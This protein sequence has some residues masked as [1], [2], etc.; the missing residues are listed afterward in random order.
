MAETPRRLA[1]FLLSVVQPAR[2]R[3][4]VLLGTVGGVRTDHSPDRHSVPSPLPSSALTAAS[5]ARAWSY[6]E[7]GDVESALQANSAADPTDPEAAAQ[8]VLLLLLSDQAA[9]ALAE[10]DAAV[11]AGAASDDLWVYR[12]EALA[13]AGFAEEAASEWVRLSN[14][15]VSRP[16]MVTFLA[17]A[18]S[19]LASH[20]PHRA[21]DLLGRLSSVASEL[22]CDMVTGD[23]PEYPTELGDMPKVLVGAARVAISLIPV[24]SPSDPLV[25]ELANSLASSALLVSLPDG[26]AAS[27]SSPEAA[28]AAAAEAHKVVFEAQA[29]A[30]DWEAAEAVAR[31]LTEAFP[32]LPDGYVAMVA[33]CEATGRDPSWWAQQA[34]CRR[35]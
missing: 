2:L 20:D 25:T 19:L 9:E 35:G 6:V 29:A 18:A 8:R 3:S 22:V 26:P 16:G 24:L 23:A 7:L 33:V 10:A 1:G 4:S 11:E 28:S 15:T 30:G 21:A 27:L 13:R 5:V 32:H 14:S 17:N 31:D 34:R 12:T